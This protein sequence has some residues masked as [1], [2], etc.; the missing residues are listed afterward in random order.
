MAHFPY[1]NTRIREYQLLQ[2]MQVHFKALPVF[3]AVLRN[4]PFRFLLY[5]SLL[6]FITLSLTPSRRALLSQSTQPCGF[7]LEISEVVRIDS[8][9]SMSP[10]SSYCWALIGNELAHLEEE[11]AAGIQ[12]KVV[13]L[14]WRDYAPREGIVDRKYVERKQQEFTSLEQAGFELILSLGFHDPPRWIHEQ[15]QNSYYVNQFGDRY[16]GQPD[17]ADVNYIFNPALRALVATYIQDV[18]TV[19]GTNFAA[20]RLGG[21]RYGELTYPAAQYKDC[22]NCYWAFDPIAR[23]RNPAPNWLPGQPSA[24]DE[25]RMFLDWYL[26]TLV[27]FQQWQIEVVRQTYDGPLM[28]LYPS[29]GIRP[30]D[31]ERA[32]AVDLDG[33]TPA[34]RNGEIQRGFDFARQIA[35]ITDP[36]V[37]VTTTWLDADASADDND[38]LRY[39]SPVKYLSVLAKIHPLYLKMF[40]ENTG[41]GSRTEMQ[42]SASQMRRHQLL[43]MAWFR[44]EELFS[45]DYATLRDYQQ[46]IASEDR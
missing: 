40:G 22:D 3:N 35:A 14:S 45:G 27:G 32:I 23:T 44:E 12:A 2:L 11:R 18:F 42:F 9:Q 24:E 31:I 46:L 19:F 10:T 41:H 20:V 16:I 43:G 30:G 5:F 38:D 4:D 37:I 8:N 13:S 36:G 7:L 17:E 1:V 21:G 33:S 39:W 29:W 34:E 25:A 15:H 26:D 28:M 6:I